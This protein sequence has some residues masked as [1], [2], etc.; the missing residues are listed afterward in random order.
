MSE[1]LGCGPE[2]VA[3][4]RAE[5]L[6]GRGAAARWK[7]VWQLRHELARGRLWKGRVW[8]SAV[9]QRGS[10]VS[11]VAQ[12][13]SADALVA[14]R[15]SRSGSRGLASG[16]SPYRPDDVQVCLELALAESELRASSLRLRPGS[17]DGLDQGPDTFESIGNE[18]L[19]VHRTPSRRVVPCVV[20]QESTARQSRVGEPTRNRDQLKAVVTGKV[21]NA[22]KDGARSY[23]LPADANCSGNRL[24]VRRGGFEP[25][26]S[27][28]AALRSSPLELPAQRTRA[29]AYTT[30]P[31]HSLS[32]ANRP[33]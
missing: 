16:A 21:E 33:V 24:V 5:G 10:S 29:D 19:A 6:A 20:N 18:S 27:A 14:L 2:L 7:G 23:A 22:R 28:S 32:A 26:A 8:R 9:E 12:R 4:I 31:P 17:D 30:G 15:V 11:S 1:H 13:S 25:S 3:C